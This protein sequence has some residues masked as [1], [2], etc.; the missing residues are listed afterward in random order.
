MS[1]NKVPISSTYLGLY[2]GP[3]ATPKP[4]EEGPIFLGIKNISEDGSLDLSEIRHIAEGDFAEWTRRVEPRAGDIVFT[5]EATLHRYAV[6]PLGF[7]GCLG[8]RLA[9]IRPNPD[10]VNTRF[11]FYY[12]FGKEWKE[13]VARN[14]LYGSTVDRIPLTDFPRLMISLPPLPTQRKIAAILGAFDDLIENNR[15]RI[16][17]LEEMARLVYRE[18]FV[19]FRFPCHENTRFVD[20]PLGPIPEGWEVRRLAEVCDLVMG[21]S[22]RSEFYNEAGEGLPFHQGVTNFGD[23]FPT[24]RVYCTVEN[25]IAEA[26]DVLFS[27]RAPVGRINVSNTK[28]VIGRGL[29]AIRSRSG[30]QSLLHHQLRERFR[31]E[32]TIGGGTI[33]KAVTRAD[34]ESIELLNPPCSVAVAFEN[35]CESMEGSIEN[36]TKR[37]QL[38]H[39][40]RDLLLPKLI[41]GGLDVSELDIDIG[42]DGP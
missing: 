9:L 21:Q 30:H 5:Y 34:M 10:V 32:D 26:G 38:L 18:W 24:H 22:P 25:R 36:L 16:E 33:F 14:T 11:L 3:H 17:I 8:R 12:F 39:S 15:R 27:V 20:S 13:T 35:H 40:A 7:R 2:D 23:R 37:N 6:I 42:E 4:S 1:W 31:E 19:N 28:M 29:A 41:S